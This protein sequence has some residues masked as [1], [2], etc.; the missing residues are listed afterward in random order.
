MISIMSALD[1]SKFIRVHLVIVIDN[2]STMVRVMAWNR[3]ATG[4]KS[5][6]DNRYLSRKVKAGQG[7]A[8]IKKENPELMIN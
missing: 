7:P 1:E 6:V 3:P 5:V 4:H 8:P 2:E